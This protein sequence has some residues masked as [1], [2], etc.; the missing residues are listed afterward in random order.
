ME[1]VIETSGNI[2]DSGGLIHS[3]VTYSLAKV[4][5]VVMLLICIIMRVLRHN[6]NDFSYKQ[7]SLYFALYSC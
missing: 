4:A 5:Q 3:A 2:S 6:F 7:G 1:Y